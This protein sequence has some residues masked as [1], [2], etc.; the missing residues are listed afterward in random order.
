MYHLFSNLLLKIPFNYLHQQ[1]PTFLAPGTQLHG[2][3]A[4]HRQDGVGGELGEV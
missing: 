4:V 3:Q 1:S 2:R